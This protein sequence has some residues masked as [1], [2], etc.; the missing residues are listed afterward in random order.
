M[1][2]RD[3]ICITMNAN[4]NNY[5]KQFKEWFEWYKDKYNFKVYV[6]TNRKHLFNDFKDEKL[7]I[8]DTEELI[9]KCPE[10][11][12]FEKV[13]SEETVTVY[14]EYPFSSHR[15]IRRRAFEDGFKTIIN[16]ESDTRF[17][18]SEE[19]IV[20]YINS[21]QPNSIYTRAAIY[22][23]STV[24][25]GRW[26][27]W[28]ALTNRM[29]RDLSIDINVDNYCTPDGTNVVF[30]F[31]KDTYESFFDDSDKFFSYYYNTFPTHDN[32]PQCVILQCCANNNI[33]VKQIENNFTNSLHDFKIRYNIKGIEE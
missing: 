18:I 16:I 30:N 19:G 22:C 7:F 23:K 15:H 12:K 17:I 31:D 10:T 25:D 6:S 9:K 2:T 26:K 24:K 11:Y 8:F 4:F 14:N 21:F 5:V 32:A 28:T 33:P 13:L 3:D 20:K 27:T 1:I 29:N